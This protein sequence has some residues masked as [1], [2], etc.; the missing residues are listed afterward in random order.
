MKY[1]DPIDYGFSEGEHTELL[2]RIIQASVL[3]WEVEDDNVEWSHAHA[4]GAQAD[5]LRYVAKQNMAI[6]LPEYQQRYD[7]AI[8]FIELENDDNADVE[9]YESFGPVDS[10]G[11]LCDDISLW[12]EANGAAGFDEVVV[13]LIRFYELAI[14]FEHE[15][16]AEFKGE[17]SERFRRLLEHVRHCHAQ[18][19]HM[20]KGKI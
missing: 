8:R 19:E 4:C 12:I 1:P 16:D 13:N 3:Y 11:G 2:R 15:N 18:I 17:N 7:R 5:I 9:A 6:G 20:K 14:W 10:L